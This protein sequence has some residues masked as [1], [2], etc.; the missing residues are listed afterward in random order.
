MIR[1]LIYL[2]IEYDRLVDMEEM[3]Y[4]GIID[5]TRDELIRAIVEMHFSL[6]TRDSPQIGLGCV[7]SNPLKFPSLLLIELK[8]FTCLAITLLFY[9]IS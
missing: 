4:L 9:N 8:G 5:R 6:V 1:A 7:T 2:N 3:A